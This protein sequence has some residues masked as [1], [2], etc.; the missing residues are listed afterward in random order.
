MG[1]LA[2]GGL[3]AACSSAPPASPTTAPAKPTEAAK[4]SA[5]AGAGQSSAPTSAPAAG[6]SPAAAASPAAS[7]SPAAAASPVAGASPAAGA[8]PSPAAAAAPAPAASAPAA[9]AKPAAAAPALTGKRGG[10]L[11]WAIEQDPVYLSPFGG[12]PT[13]NMWGKEF[14]Y[15][16]LL[17][18]DKELGIKPALAETW[19]TPDDKTWVFHLRK[20]VKFHDGKELDS[21]DV[22][23]SFEMQANPPPPGSTKTYYPKIASID[24]PDKYTVKLNMSAPDPTVAGYLAWARYSPMVPKGLYDKVNTSTQGIGTGPFKLVEYIQNDHV[25]Y[26]RYADFWKP[27]LPYLDELTLKVMPDE[28]A[29]IAALR[30]GAIDGCTVSA[31]GA[32]TLKADSSLTVLYGLFAAHRETQLTLKDKSK[33]WSEKK[34]RQAVSAAINRQDIID[35]VFGG[36]A[37]YSAEIPPGYG[38]WPIPEAELKGKFFAQDLEKAKRLMSEAG[39]SNGFSV[40]LQSIVGDNT[41]IAEVLKEQLSAIKIDL[42]VVPLEIGTFAKNNGEG[43]FEWHQTARGMRGDVSNYIQ[44]FRPGNATSA[45]WFGEG[46][47]NPE[48]TQLIDQGLATVDAAKRKDIYR[49]A[50]EIL[51][52]ESPHITL[53]QPYKYQVVRNRVKDM[54]VAYSDFNSGLREA[55][56]DG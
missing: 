8:S 53:C 42:K 44:E 27:G 35:K 17:E 28:Q 29:R 2:A 55:W 11:T 21:E 20:G 40:E 9:A 24:L 14:M 37:A 16:S 13:A 30:S 43:T 12:I 4:P 54:Y 45:A 47:Q 31:D 38:D 3:L 25:T 56:I 34:V 22:K 48:L 19:E 39:M 52:D 26:T 5:P 15:D 41:L 10:K 23:Y 50:Q 36:D 32:R 6:A 49:K 1:I 18:W 46:W 51:I 33:P 7:A